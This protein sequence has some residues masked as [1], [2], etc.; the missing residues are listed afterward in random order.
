[1]S[2]TISIQKLIRVGKTI[3]T[4]YLSS[5]CSQE[6]CWNFPALFKPSKLEQVDYICHCKNTEIH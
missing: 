5:Y 4:N 6:L 2:Y 3:N 1:M